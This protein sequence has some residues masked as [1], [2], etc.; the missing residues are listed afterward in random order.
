MFART[1]AACLECAAFPGVLT[2]PARPEQLQLLQE[3]VLTMAQYFS[4]KT[5]AGL[6]HL[7]CR[8]SAFGTLR[9]LDLVGTPLPA[10]TVVNVAT[11]FT[12]LIALRQLR[13]GSCG[14]TDAA[15]AAT[16]QAVAACPHLVELSLSH[17]HLGSRCG[18]ALAVALP[19]MSCLNSLEIDHCGLQDQDGALILGALVH[20]A[21]WQF[22]SLAG[23]P[24]HQCTFVR[25][26]PLLSR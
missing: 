1:V 6:G 25:L 21:S 7:T 24:S 22:V 20:H 5:H 18:A 10:A 19:D 8:Q 2:V 11:S 12:A 14:L 16:V 3:L 15:G 17:N 26:C 13:L 23:E 4:V 9:K